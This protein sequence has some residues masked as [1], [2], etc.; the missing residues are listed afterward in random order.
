MTAMAR[1]VKWNPMIYGKGFY[2]MMEAVLVCVCCAALFSLA[3]RVVVRAC[4]GGV[5]DGVTE[6]AAWAWGA[7][8]AVQALGCALLLREGLLAGGVACAVAVLV[9]AVACIPLACRRLSE[10]TLVQ[11]AHGEE[12][13]FELDDDGL[14]HE[15]ASAAASENPTATTS[16]SAAESAGG[17][18]AEGGVSG[19]KKTFS[20][21]DCGGMVAIRCA[22]VARTY[23]LTRREEDVLRLLVSG[24]TVPQI[25]E[26][27]VLSPHTVKSHVRNLY[28]KLGVSG[29]SE[30]ADRLVAASARFAE[31]PVGLG[32][33]D[34]CFLVAQPDG[35]L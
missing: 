27:L 2:D 1:A 16:K 18:V 35:E 30:L 5:V 13:R 32:N 9:L 25:A 14:L 12:V 31:G 4:F 19:T 8:F 17:N 20:E 26:R 6:G 3:A 11:Q 23:D 29:R 15:G 33:D 24:M 7:S 21:D 10:K 34:G 22:Y 28:R